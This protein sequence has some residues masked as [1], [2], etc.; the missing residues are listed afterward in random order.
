MKGRSSPAA[1]LAPLVC[2]ALSFAASNALAQAKS[3]AGAWMLVT[4]V[5]TDASGKKEATYGEKPM[6]QIVFSPNGRYTLLISKPDVPKVAANNR[7]KG[8]PEENKAVVGGTLSHYGSYKVDDKAKAIVF[9]IE[10][11]T[12]PNWNGT[13]Q[14]RPYSMTGDELKWT[15]PQS[16]G[17]G[18]SDLVWKRVK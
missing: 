14:Q 12:F 13:Q 6:G 1:L 5:S 15:T 7:V 10:A 18:T 4:N 17:G 16:S 11:S 2:L 3:I 9:N 8:T